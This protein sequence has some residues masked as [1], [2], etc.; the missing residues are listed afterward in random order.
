MKRNTELFIKSS[1]QKKIYN[2][3]KQVFKFFVC[4]ILS[5]FFFQNFKWTHLS[6]FVPCVGWGSIILQ[7]PSP[8]HFLMSF[9]LLDGAHIPLEGYRSAV[10]IHKKKIVIRYISEREIVVRPKKCAEET[11][12]AIHMA[13]ESA[14]P[15]GAFV[16]IPGVLHFSLDE[17]F[18][19][20]IILDNLVVIEFKRTAY[21]ISIEAE[22]EDGDQKLLLSIHSAIEK[23]THE[24]AVP[25][26]FQPPH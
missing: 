15:N 21:T 3:E 6:P 19:A 23:L 4:L 7:H 11:L 12:D 9:V 18:A 8:S 10:T 22:K 13:C 17:Y 20:N 24:G 16:I 14:F 1:L 5:V 2:L 25:A 26:P